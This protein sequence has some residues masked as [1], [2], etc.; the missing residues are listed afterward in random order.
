MSNAKV[1]T[2]QNTEVVAI[3]AQQTIEQDPNGVQMPV[4][5]SSIRPWTA[6]FLLPSIRYREPSALKIKG[7]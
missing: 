4:A 6:D 2:A 1:D 3:N 7:H 5:T